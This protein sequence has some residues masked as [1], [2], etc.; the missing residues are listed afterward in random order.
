[1]VDVAQFLANQATEQFVLQ[2]AVSRLRQSAAG[3]ATTYIWGDGGGDYAEVLGGGFNT[4]S[5]QDELSSDLD[6]VIGL[7][8]IS[9][10]TSNQKI[11]QVGKPQNYVVFRRIESM[12]LQ[13]DRD[14][15]MYRFFF[16]NAG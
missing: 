6:Q 14:Q 15:K 11:E 2:H 10:V 3:S 5:Q 16:N 4:Q 9:R 1:M 13:S 8:E 12:L 7:R